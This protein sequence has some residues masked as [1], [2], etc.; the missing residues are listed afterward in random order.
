MV[1]IITQEY[2]KQHERVKWIIQGLDWSDINEFDMLFT[3]SDTVTSWERNF[4][5]SVETQSDE[6]KLLTKRQMDIL[7]RIYKEKSR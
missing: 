7:D 2:K 1:K 4:I 3:R 5:E 6:G